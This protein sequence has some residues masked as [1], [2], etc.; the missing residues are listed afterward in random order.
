M[1]APE[2]FFLDHDWIFPPCPYNYDSSQPAAIKPARGPVPGR[3]R[4]SSGAAHHIGSADSCFP[5]G[6]S[7]LPVHPAK[8]AILRVA[9][10]PRRRMVRL[11]LAAQTGKVS[12]GK[13]G[14]FR[15]GWILAAAL[16]KRAAGCRRKRALVKGGKALPSGRFAPHPPGCGRRTAT[17]RVDEPG[18]GLDR[19]VGEFPGGQ[20]WFWKSEWQSQIDSSI[21]HIQEGKV[22]VFSSAKEAPSIL[23][24]DI[25][26][27][28]HYGEG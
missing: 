27:T 15:P 11:F 28:D 14:I 2:K 21:K 18:L 7:N 9:F 13:Q 26:R 5:S 3:S 8:Q 24:T 23:A 12:E 25:I 16:T 4:G 22:K 10:F 20:S 17:R 1:T 6:N 19:P